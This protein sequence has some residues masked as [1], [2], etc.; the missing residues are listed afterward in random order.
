MNNHHSAGL[1]FDWFWFSSFSTWVRIRKYVFCLFKYNT[2][3]LVTCRTVILPHR[4]SILWI[5]SITTVKR[6]NSLQSKGRGFT[7]Y[8]V[9]SP[10][11]TLHYGR[12]QCFWTLQTRAWAFRITANY[13]TI[14]PKINITLLWNVFWDYFATARLFYTYGQSY[15]AST[16]IIYDSRV[17]CDWKIPHIPTLES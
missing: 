1:Q 14:G 16:I 11:L 15:K 6:V 17:V 10:H 12:Q 8:F 2:V 9:T 13:P 7:S 5:P 4:V 3:K